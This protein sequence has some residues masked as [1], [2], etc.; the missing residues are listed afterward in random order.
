M[1]IPR[2][3]SFTLLISR[4]ISPRIRTKSDGFAS[5]RTILQYSPNCLS[6]AII[7]RESRKSVASSGAA[8]ARLTPKDVNF[9][10]RTV[11]LLPPPH[12]PREYR[13]VIL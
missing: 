10:D 8:V 12:L 7:K 5:K 2:A 11:F 1:I 4:F 6:K 9:H 13:D 3:Q